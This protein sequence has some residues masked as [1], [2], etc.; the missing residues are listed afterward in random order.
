M[1]QVYLQLFRPTDSSLF[2][3]RDMSGIL[4]FIFA[5]C[6]PLT[7]LSINVCFLF[8]AYNTYKK[9]TTTTKNTENKNIVVAKVVDFP[10]FGG[11]SD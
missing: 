4:C 6:E 11:M 1:F 8:H 7:H 2:N 10:D 9:T 5:S 3:G